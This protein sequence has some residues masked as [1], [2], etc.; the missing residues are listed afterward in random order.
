M[1]FTWEMMDMLRSTLLAVFCAVMPLLSVLTPAV[2]A[3]KDPLVFE[4]RTY[5]AKPGKL[6]ALEKRFRDHTL[7]LFE[8]HGMTN[9]GYWVPQD[10]PKEMLIYVLGHKSKEAA[11]ESWK[12]FGADPEW[13]AAYKESEKDGKLVEKAEVVYMQPTDYSPAIQPSKEG[14]RVFELRVYK[15]APNALE[16]LHDRFRNHTVKLFEKHGMTNLY[17]W[18]VMAGQ[19][20]EGDTLIYI[21]AHKSKEAGL[22]SFEKFRADPDWIKART[23]SEAKY[24]GSLTADGGVVSTYMNATDYSPTK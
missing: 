12:A 24:G 15:A 16:Q 22:Q 4:M 8:K 19:P 9:L 1:L 17:Y 13:Q 20:G 14:N 10:N 23:D 2:A 3:D 18:K 11:A 6:A 7:K 21:L 5:Y